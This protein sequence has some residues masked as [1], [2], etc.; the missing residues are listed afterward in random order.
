[1]PRLVPF[2]TPRYA[3]GGCS[4]TNHGPLLEKTLWFFILMARLP[5]LVEGILCHQKNAS[6]SKGCPVCPNLFGVR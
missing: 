6:A 3:L 1:M 5:E 2:D 4:G